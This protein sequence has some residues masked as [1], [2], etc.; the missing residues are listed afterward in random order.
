MPVCFLKMYQNKKHW[1]IEEIGD[2]LDIFWVFLSSEMLL[3][4]MDLN[5]SSCTVN[6][7]TDLD[8][9]ERYLGDKQSLSA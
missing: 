3:R 2:F 8:S 7:Q 1:E 4:M 5:I 6:P 9:A